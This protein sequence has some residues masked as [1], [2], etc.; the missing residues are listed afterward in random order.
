MEDARVQL[1]TATTL[2]PTD[3]NALANLAVTCL[4]LGKFDEMMA[5]RTRLM[6]LHSG[7][8]TALDDQIEQKTGKRP[9]A[10]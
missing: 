3:D 2:D 10:P 9:D 6:G 7:L 5:A 1:T 4:E 8:L